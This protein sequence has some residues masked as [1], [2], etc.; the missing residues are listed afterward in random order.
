MHHWG[1]YVSKIGIWTGV[2]V[3]CQIDTTGYIECRQRISMVSSE[4]E[5]CIGVTDISL[6]MLDNYGH[7]LP[8]CLGSVVLENITIRINT[9]LPRY[10]VYYFNHSPNKPL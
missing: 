5:H 9:Q 7:R 6:G 2:M 10:S 1:E 3:A 8:G 4:S